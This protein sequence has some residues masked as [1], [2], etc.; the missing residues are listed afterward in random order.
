MYIKEPSILEVL[1]GLLRTKLCDYSL[2]MGN[3]TTTLMLVLMLVSLPSLQA[4][5]KFSVLL[6][7][8][9]YSYVEESY[10]LHPQTS[11]KGFSD[12]F[13]NM[14]ILHK[15]LNLFSSVHLEILILILFL[16]MKY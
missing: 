2:R 15:R 13:H 5:G 1:F 9:I 7:K 6:T 12:L 4:Y 14:Y 10:F 11:G 3:W 16:N 8:K